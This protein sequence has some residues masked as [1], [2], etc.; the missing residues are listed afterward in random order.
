MNKLEKEVNRFKARLAGWIAKVVYFISTYDGSPSKPSGSDSTAIP[1]TEHK[2]D[3]DKTPE[4][5]EKEE[6]VS[7]GIKIVS[8][9]SPN[10]A[11]AKEDPNTQI[12]DLKISKSGLSYRWAKGNLR[13]WGIMNDHS[14]KALAVAGYGDGKTFRCSKFDWIST[15]R[16][17]RDF[18]NIDEG[19]NGFKAAEFWKAKHRCF[20]IMT[21]H[22]TKRTNILVG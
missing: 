15:D 8:F 6:I 21:E 1:E 5:P 12:K 16:L 20:F 11:N 14:A 9:G 4:K 7:S 13:N 2:P 10:C 17:T 18:V 3:E 19:Y 22:G